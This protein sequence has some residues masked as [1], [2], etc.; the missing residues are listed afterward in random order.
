MIFFVTYIYTIVF[1]A[2]LFFISALIVTKC[3]TDQVFTREE[4]A[5]RIIPI[6]IV[7]YSMDF[8]GL[9]YKIIIYSFSDFIFAITTAVF[10]I[11]ILINAIS[12]TVK[13]LQYIGAWRYLAVYCFA[14]Y[15]LDIIL[16]LILIILD[17]KRQSE[18]TT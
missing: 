13:R 10:L 16:T 2:L 18:E 11:L 17:R 8:F 6:H 1:L 4:Y 12:W 15:Y 5:K 7:F 9:I 3:K 14:P